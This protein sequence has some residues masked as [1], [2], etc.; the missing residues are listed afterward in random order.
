M[1]RAAELATIEDL[2][3]DMRRLVDRMLEEHRG[4]LAAT[5]RCGV[6]GTSRSSGRSR[7]SIAA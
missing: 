1:A 5:G 6:T 7:F 3:A 2:P 4:H